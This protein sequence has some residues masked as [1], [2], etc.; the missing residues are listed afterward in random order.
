M[1]INVYM[2]N[3][4]H[5]SYISGYRNNEQ[6]LHEHNVFADQIHL[7]I[8]LIFTSTIFLRVFEF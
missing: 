4:M 1:Y 6:C 7:V 8:F 3:N 2:T 5:I